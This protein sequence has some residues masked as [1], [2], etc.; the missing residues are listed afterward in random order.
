MV[1]PS[2]MTLSHLKYRHL[3]LIVH[4]AEHGTVHKAAQHLGISQPAATAMLNDLEALVGLRLFERS[5]RGVVPSEQARPILDC[6]R[7]MLNEFSNFAATAGRI[8]DGRQRVLRVGVVPQAYVT[9][10]PKAIE[11]FRAA[12]GCAVRAVEG[13]SQQLLTQLLEGSLDCVIGRLPSGGLAEKGSLSSLAYVDLYDEEICIAVSADHEESKLAA[14]TYPDLTKREWVLQRRDSSVR[15]ALNE[16]FLRHGVAVPEP[17]LETA[18]YMQS[19]AVVQATQYFTVAPRQAVETQQQLGLVKVVS[20]SLDIAPMQ[21]SF[22]NRM[23]GEADPTIAL[24]KEVVAR[25][26]NIVCSIRLGGAGV[27]VMC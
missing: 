20:F 26:V 9:Y 22:I 6:A 12:G 23:T 2:L 8:A 25:A 16:A 18:N 4:L 24:F 7:T 27:A 15:H 3:M 10:L 17:V 5:S 21:V 11:G 1:K 14:L 13:T 19:L